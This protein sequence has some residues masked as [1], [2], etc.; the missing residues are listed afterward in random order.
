MLMSMIA[1]P[2]SSLSFAASAITCG[3]QPASC[4]DTGSST[5]SHSDFCSDWRVSRI[6]AWLAIIS[7]TVRPGAVALDD[8]PERQVGDA[9][10]RREDHRRVDPDADRSGWASAGS[11][12][13]AQIMEKPLADKGSAP[14]APRSVTTHRTYRRRRQRRAPRRRRAQAISDAGRQAGAALGG[15]G[16]ASASRPP[17]SLRVVIGEGQQDI[18][19]AA[20][21][22]P[23][24]GAMVEGGAERADSV[25]AG[26]GR[27]RAATPCWSMTRPARS[28]RP[29]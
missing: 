8:A 15:G 21:G 24:V 10:H 13:R 5:G 22:G 14:R 9:R 27:D 20:L 3:S 11:W 1:A 28:A 16:D 25:R 12:E 2:R 23:D 4:I 26:L 19:A 7:V 18:A 29:T 6:I 17:R